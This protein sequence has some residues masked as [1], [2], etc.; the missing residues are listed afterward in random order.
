MRP[1]AVAT[2][3]WLVVGLA[4]VDYTPAAGLIALVAGGIA[5]AIT[6]KVTASSSP[7]P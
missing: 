1:W 5:W 3:V 4:L 7:H 2:I 6:E